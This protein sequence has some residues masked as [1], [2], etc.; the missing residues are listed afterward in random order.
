MQGN[1]PRIVWWFLVNHLCWITLTY[2]IWGSKKIKLLTLV[3][4]K[5]CN[6]IFCKLSYQ[7]YIRAM[8]V[9]SEVKGCKIDQYYAWEIFLENFCV[10]CSLQINPLQIANMADK[11][12]GLFMCCLVKLHAVFVRFW[13]QYYQPNYDTHYTYPWYV[14][15]HIHW[16]RSSCSG[17]GLKVSWMLR[18]HHIT[19]SI[20]QI[21]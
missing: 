9:T 2:L 18:T 21:C 4:N 12:S 14:D 19:I 8:G 20:D 13:D 10:S 1:T 15:P 7:L 16:A 5:N 3:L 6:K 11:N 17:L